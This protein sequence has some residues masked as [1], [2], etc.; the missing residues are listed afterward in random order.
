MQTSESVFEVPS[1]ADPMMTYTVDVS[2]GVCACADGLFGRFCKHQAAV[3]FHKPGMYHSKVRFVLIE[4]L[5]FFLCV[6][7]Y[8]FIFVEN[9]FEFIKLFTF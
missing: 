8:T 3:M 6:T 5:Q 1:E 7:L 2:A 9:N 4:M